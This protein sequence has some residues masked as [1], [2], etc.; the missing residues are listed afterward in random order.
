MKRVAPAVGLLALALLG[1]LLALLAHDAPLAPTMARGWLQADALSALTM[2]VLG[3]QGLVAWVRDP[4][5]CWPTLAAAWLFG[6]AAVMGHLGLM[7]GLLLL[8]G[9]VLAAQTGARSALVSTC[10][11]CLGLVVLGVTGGAW[12]YGAPGA[13][14]GLN[15]LSFALLLAGALGAAGA[16]RMVQ[17]RVPADTPLAAVAGL[18]TLLRLFSLGPWNL[19]W[20]FAALVVGG[21]TALWAAWQAAAAPPAHVAAWLGLYFSGLVMVGAGLGSGAGVTLAGYALLTWPV[22]RLGLVRPDG[23]RWPLWLLTGAVPLSAPFVAAWLAV[24]AAVAGG[25]TLLA[26][27][28]WVA[29]LLVVVAVGRFAVQDDALTPLPPLPL[30]GEGEARHGVLMGAAAMLSVALGVGAPL[31]V[32]GLGPL[33]AQLQGGLTPFGAIS[34]WPWAG[35]VALNAAQQPVA[36]LPSLALIV[37]MGMLAALCWVALRLVALWGRRNG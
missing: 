22:V 32:L 26:A 16:H 23:P 3:A 25:L 13:G 10:G 28:L 15:S 31:V 33:V 18:T 17:G 29:A 9:A 21:A 7:A 14:A 34:L 2:I 35:L 8:G 12:H 24:A 4:R 27:L 19:G 37:L 20:L 11:A 36:T 30:R 1:M 6:A 5:R